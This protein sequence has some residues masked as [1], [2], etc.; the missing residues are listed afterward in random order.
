LA[1]TCRENIYL[2]DSSVDSG[3]VNYHEFGNDNG[4]DL[5]SSIVMEQRYGINRDIFIQWL[6]MGEREATCDMEHPC[7]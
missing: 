5:I 7:M 2:P 4:G 3:G 6:A 1:F